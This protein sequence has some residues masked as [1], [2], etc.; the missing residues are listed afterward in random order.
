MPE[1]NIVGLS[2]LALL[3]SQFISVAATPVR[4]PQVSFAGPSS[5]LPHG[6]TFQEWMPQ[7]LDDQEMAKLLNQ[8]A[9]VFKLSYGSSAGR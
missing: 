6:K 5:S 3:G 9:P 7:N 8:Y 4:V 1:K 2:S